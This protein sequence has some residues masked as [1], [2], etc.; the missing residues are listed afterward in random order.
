MS[1]RLTRRD[2]LL[3]LGAGGVS[4]V[5]RGR[6]ALASPG[7][8]NRPPLAD[9]RQAQAA[10]AGTPTIPPSIRLQMS[11]GSFCSIAMEEY[12]KGVVP[13]EMPA[14]W[15][16]EALKAQAVAARTYAAAYVATYG[17]ICG[18]SA[19]QNWNP[20]NR[21]A[22]SD[23][24]VAATAGELMT[25]QG[26]MIWANYSSTCGG[27]TANSPDAASA[28]CQSARCGAGAPADLS[29]EAAAAAF[30]GNPQTAYCSGSSLFRWTYAA[31]RSTEDQ[32]LAQYMNNQS[33]ASI[34]VTSREYSGK[35][36]NVRLNG[37]FNVTGESTIKT[38]LRPTVSGSSLP[39]ANVILTFDGAT[40]TRKGG[41]FGH[42]I[43]LCQWGANGMA[44]AGAT[45]RQILQHYYTGIAFQTVAPSSYALPA[46]RA[47]RIALPWASR[48]GGASSGA[49][50][51]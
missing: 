38:A 23:A 43:G 17:Y 41:G 9:G 20:A 7:P 36:T 33:L 24:A 4:L 45:Y 40:L 47:F 48:A 49:A 2:L 10:T 35:A 12:V 15:P 46:T 16:A 21:T 1:L 44:T 39:S 50:C 19:C 32:I 8:E 51:G 28:Y 42:G 14:G 25:Y 30:W 6:L 37:S 18:T 29:S 5:T 3:V 27:Q 13:A 11:D 22:A 26:G 31:A 34:A